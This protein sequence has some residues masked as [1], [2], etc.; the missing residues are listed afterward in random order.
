MKTSGV[1]AHRKVHVERGEH[2]GKVR[3]RGSNKTTKPAVSYPAPRLAPASPFADRPVKANLRGVRSADILWL[4]ATAYRPSTRLDISCRRTSPSGGG[5]A[6]GAAP[7]GTWR[8]EPGAGR[9]RGGVGRAGEGGGGG[10]GDK[11]GGDS[12]RG[13]VAGRWGRRPLP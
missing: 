3:S 7:G 9:G 12:I 1:Y 6:A 5:C 10:G 2:D 13:R 4:C 8:H 11:G